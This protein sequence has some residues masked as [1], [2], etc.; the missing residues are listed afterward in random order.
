MKKVA[1]TDIYRVFAKIGESRKLYIPA[2][3]GVSQARFLPYMEGMQLTEK[4]KN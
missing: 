2:D 4:L 3:D 1:I